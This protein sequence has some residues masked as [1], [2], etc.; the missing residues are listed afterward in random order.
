[1]PSSRR[2]GTNTIP[3]PDGK[4]RT[5]E[6]ELSRPCDPRDDEAAAEKITSAA[7]RLAQ[8]RQRRQYS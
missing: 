7:D 8:E 1:M 6:R 3:D 5:K 4:L 2:S